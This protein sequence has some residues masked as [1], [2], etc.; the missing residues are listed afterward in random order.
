MKA[1]LKFHSGETV[2]GVVTVD[3]KVGGWFYI[4][5]NADEYNELSHPEFDDSHGIFRDSFKSKEAALADFSRFGE[6][7]G[8]DDE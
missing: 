2:E 4:F 1:R 8:D 3:H 7:I 5:T 6:I